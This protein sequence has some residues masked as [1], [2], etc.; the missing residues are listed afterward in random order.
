MGNLVEID[1]QKVIR[2]GSSPYVL[3]PQALRRDPGAE[4]GDDVVFLRS[5]GS[6][7]IIIHIEKQIPSG[8]ERQ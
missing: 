4:V 3:I 2:I 6:T 7:D 1:R 5:A 8:G